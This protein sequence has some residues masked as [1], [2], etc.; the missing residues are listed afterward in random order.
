MN[1]RLRIDRILLHGPAWSAGEQRLFERDFVALLHET[2][3]LQLRESAFASVGRS[4]PS[5][6]MAADIDLSAA[7]Q[8]ALGLASSLV[9]QM[10]VPPGGSR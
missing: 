9:R 4:E 7:R 2:L 3:T 1:L 5:E 6:F 10:A 8:A